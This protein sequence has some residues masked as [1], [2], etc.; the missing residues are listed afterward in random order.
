ML[1]KDFTLLE[2]LVVIAVIAILAS[3]LLPALSKAQQT[4]HRT[5]CINNLKQ[6]GIGFFLYAEANDFCS[7]AAR[8]ENPLGND[9][10]WY[11]ENSSYGIVA[12]YLN[13]ESGSGAYIPPFGGCYKTKH[14]VPYKSALICPARGVPGERTTVH[15]RFHGFGMNT[16]LGYER[17]IGFGFPLDQVKIPA[18]TCHAAES[19]SGGV[20]YRVL[21]SDDYPIRFPHG[22]LSNTLFIDGHVKPLSVHQIPDQDKRTDAWSSS[23]WCPGPTMTKSWHDNW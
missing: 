9:F 2:L 8:I 6:L 7:P 19:Q 15:T 14:N 18:R 16:R 22:N 4:A 13:L 21:S 1:K 3:M 20:N 11:Y 12:E 5:H 23:F 17:G 10:W